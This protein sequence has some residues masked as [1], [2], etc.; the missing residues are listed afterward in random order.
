MY[1]HRDESKL[2]LVMHS[3]QRGIG[4][5]QVLKWGG[6]VLG[7]LVG[8]IA[9]AALVVVVSNNSR[10]NKVYDIPSNPVAIPDD[11]ETLDEGERLFQARGCV[12]CHGQAGGGYYLIDDPTFGTL[13]GSNLTAGENG[14]GAA[15]TDED[16]ER[17]I[18]HGVAPNG[19]PLLAMPSAEYFLLSDADTA[20]LIAYIKTLDP[21]D[22]PDAPS[23]SRLGP[24]ASLLF[25]T[26]AADFIGAEIIDHD[27]PRPYAEIEPEVNE[28]FGAYLASGCIGCHGPN[29]SG[30]PVPGAAPDDP[31]ASNLT[32]H[33]EGAMVGWTE[34]DFKRVLRTGIRPDGSELHP[35][36]P[37]RALSNMTDTEISALWLFLQTVEPFPTEAR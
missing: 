32:P 23:R 19:R 25:F 13:W 33:P 6:I 17:A 27:A 14:V 35:S 5:K 12:D 9:I 20:A 15:Y 4:V 29:W 37:W 22:T 36:M 28:E 16:W 10:L 31:I 8:L 24:I 3:S 1:C 30:R 21:V 7:V 26:G 34:E 2:I 18:R 11:P